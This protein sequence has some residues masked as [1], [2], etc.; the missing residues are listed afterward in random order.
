MLA[1]CY[2][3]TR[4]GVR[5][6]GECRVFMLGHGTWLACCP[7]RRSTLDNHV[8]GHTLLMQQCTLTLPTA[9]KIDEASFPLYIMLYF[10][11]LCVHIQPGDR[12]NC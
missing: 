2:R 10:V 7:G 6:E 12:P 9:T 5:R 8:N 11:R 1:Y 4:D 3:K